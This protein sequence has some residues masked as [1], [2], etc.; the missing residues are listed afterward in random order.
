MTGVLYCPGMPRHPFEPL[1]RPVLKDA[2]HAAWAEKRYW[3][4]ALLAGITLTSSVYDIGG[5]VLNLFAVPT[6]PG[7]AWGMMW[8]RATG[9][10]SQMS[11]GD[12]IIGGLKVFQLTVFFLLVVFAVMALSFIAQ[13]ALVYALG[14]RSRGR[15]PKLKEAFTVGAR[16]FWPIL[17]LNLCVMIVIWSVRALIAISLSGAIQN[18]TSLSYLSYIVAFGAFVVIA[19]AMIMIQVFALNAMILQGATLA[20][21]LERASHV[22][23]RHWVVALEAAALLFVI[24]IGASVLVVAIN[25]L[26][27]VPLFMLAVLAATFQSKLLLAITLYLAVFLFV[28]AML[29]VGGFLIELHYATWTILYRKI[30]EGGAVPKLHR[31]VRALTHGYR[32]PGA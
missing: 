16:A 15:S 11:L 13:G 30:G 10:W 26:L 6:V 4:V 18:T 9:V 17:V 27:G 31:F 2:F 19:A 22:L 7:N 5:R 20:Q 32:V 23:A 14:T 3:P 28:A 12:T 1:Y 29:A 21:A 24:T 25:M 8:V